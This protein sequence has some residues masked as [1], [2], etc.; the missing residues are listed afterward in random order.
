MGTFLQLNG[1]PLLAEDDVLIDMALKIATYR[2]HAFSREQLAA[3]IAEKT[4]GK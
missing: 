2:D 3:W 1:K 4:A